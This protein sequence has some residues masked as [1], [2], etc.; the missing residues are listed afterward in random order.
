[1]DSL[2]ILNSGRKVT[3]AV[4]VFQA[5]IFLLTFVW[6]FGYLGG[7]S[8][9]PVVTDTETGE[10][11]TFGI[12]NWH[13]LLNLL[14]F[15]GCMA[16]AIMT[17]SYPLMTI[18]DRKTKKLVHTG[19]HCGAVV[20]S[21][22]ALVAALKSHTLKKPMPMSNFYSTHSFLGIVTFVM[23]L[24]QAALGFMAFLFP[25]WSLAERQSFA[26]LH[27]FFG[28]ATFVTGMMTIM[29]RSY[30]CLLLCSTTVLIS[31]SD[32]IRAGMERL[33][34]PSCCRSGYKRRQHSYSSYKSQVSDLH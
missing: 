32:G 12:F 8:F 1:M 33:W 27:K 13:P 25:Q 10:N 2:H 11:D 20:L 34:F 19:L 16:E 31:T 23:F 4:R 9:S 3:I 14:A 7:L 18:G 26:P 29:V 30:V 17:Y 28:G 21:L 24:A 5:V 6:I 15:V 22:L